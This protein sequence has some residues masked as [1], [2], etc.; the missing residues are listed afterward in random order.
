MTNTLH[1]RGSQEELENDFVVFALPKLDIFPLEELIKKLRVFTKICLRHGPINMGK[2]KD[3]HLSR[4]DPT[5]I[6]ED[7][8]DSIALTAVYDN[9]E[10]V[11]ALINDLK[12]ADLKISI[13]ISGLLDATDHCCKRSGMKRHSVE[14]SLGV[15]GQTDRLPPREI[16]EINTLCGHGL[17]SF[18]LIQKIIEEI[19]LERM[20]S[21]QGA[22]YLA[23]PCECG[24]FN[25]HSAQHILERLRLHG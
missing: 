13:N 7:M 4:V 9:I 17:V 3:F 2:L 1:R 11:A 5:R 14:Q 23:K 6:E 8:Q 19:K 25:I 22:L 21:R 15:F 12:E 24:V 18:N 20:T 10:S 16:V